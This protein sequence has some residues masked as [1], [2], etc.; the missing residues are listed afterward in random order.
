MKK[1]FRNIADA[2]YLDKLEDEIQENKRLKKDLN[3][4]EKKIY[5]EHRRRS[6][7]MYGNSFWKYTIVAIASAAI[8]YSYPYVKDNRY[9][10]HNINNILCRLFFCLDTE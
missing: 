7:A 6:K 4:I 2:E 3:K 1:I 5:K 10:R 9:V 8:T